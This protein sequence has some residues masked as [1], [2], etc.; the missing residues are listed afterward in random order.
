MR[1]TCTGPVALRGTSMSGSTTITIL[2][3]L[4]AVMAASRAARALGICLGDAAWRRDSTLLASRPGD[5]PSL[6]FRRVRRS[7]YGAQVFARAASAI[8][9]T[10]QCCGACL[11]TLAEEDSAPCS[12]TSLPVVSSGAAPLDFARGRLPAAQSRDLPSTICGLVW[13]EGLSTLRL[14]RFGRDDGGEASLRAGSDSPVSSLHCIPGCRSS[15]YTRCKTPLGE[16]H[17]MRVRSP[18]PWGD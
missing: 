4:L 14:R 9:R 1:A 11:P 7:L 13:R 15:R 5:P 12:F 18:V 8:D 6:V 2:G 17:V 10:E 16:L 3:R